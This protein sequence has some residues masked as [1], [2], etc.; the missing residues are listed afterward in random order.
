MSIDRVALAMT[1]ASGAPYGL[2]MLQVLLGAGI[3]VDLMISTP[4]RM[5]IESETGLRLSSRPADIRSALAEHLAFHARL[6]RPAWID[7][8]R[9]TTAWWPVHGELPS[10]RASARSHSPASFAQR[11]IFIDGRDVPRIRP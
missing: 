7:A 1:G 9:L 2:R 11:L 8:T 3:G 5:V 6:D 4:G 10:T